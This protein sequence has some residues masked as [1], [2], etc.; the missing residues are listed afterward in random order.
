MHRSVVRAGAAIG[1]A[2]WS[3]L[4]G[5]ILVGGIDVHL[6]PSRAAI[7]GDVERAGIAKEDT[8]GI[9]VIHDERPGPAIPSPVEVAAQSEIA[10]VRVLVGHATAIGGAGE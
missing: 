5:G 1:F 2:F 10:R 4:T 3:G 7:A 8:I 9:V 6:V